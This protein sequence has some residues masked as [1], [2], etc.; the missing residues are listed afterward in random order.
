MQT[1][2]CTLTASGI[3]YLSNCKKNLTRCLTVIVHL[4]QSSALVRLTNESGW[5]K[6]SLLKVSYIILNAAF[7][8]TK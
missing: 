4:L 2:P 1:F 5:N 7:L 3:L 6:T 8:K